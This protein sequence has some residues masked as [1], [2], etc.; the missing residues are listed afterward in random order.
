VET[1]EGEKTLT[2]IRVGDYRIIY[3]IREGVL[4]VL[5]VR[6]PPR[7]GRIPQ[8]FLPRQGRT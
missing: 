1:L 5:V 3:Q 8:G 2:R 4:V 7:M 6:I